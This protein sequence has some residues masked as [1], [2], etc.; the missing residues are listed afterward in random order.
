MI[1]IKDDKVQITAMI[2]AIILILIFFRDMGSIILVAL[3]STI[4]LGGFSLVLANVLITRSVAGLSRYSLIAY[5]I[6]F[7]LRS[8]LAILF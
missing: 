8:L 2:L 6:C 4:Q 1:Y 3:A 7:G 5:S